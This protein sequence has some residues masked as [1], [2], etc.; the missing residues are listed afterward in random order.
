MSQP[1]A[2]S[3]SPRTGR[4]V[5]RTFG[6]LELR[7]C[8]TE[9]G[10]TSLAVGGKPLALLAYVACSATRSV[11]RDRIAEV[12]W[13]NSG[14]ESALQSIRQARTSLK[15]LAGQELVYLQG[16]TLYLADSLDTDFTA[17]HDLLAAGKLPDAV[18]LYR[19]PF[20]DL[21]AT[22]GADEFERWA[23]ALRVTYR[24]QCADALALLAGQAL[25]DARATDAIALGV[26]LGDI[27]PYDERRWRIRLEALLLKQDAF[28]IKATVADC[29]GWLT[30]EDRDPS[31][32]LKGV[33]ERAEAHAT[34]SL[35]PTLDSA[36]AGRGLHPDLV[37]REAEFSSVMESWRLA[38]EGR[39][40]SLVLVGRAG[41]G[42]SRLLHDVYERLR[43]SKSRVVL[44]RALPADS[45]VPFSLVSRVAAEL[46]NLR[47]AGAVSERSAGILVGLNP[48]LA[49]VFAARPIQ[50]GVGNP[51][52]SYI[53]ALHELLRVLA[54]EKR[55]AVLVDDLHWADTESAQVVASLCER[56]QQS[57]ILFVLATRSRTVSAGTLPTSATIVPIVTLTPEDTSNLLA[58][59]ASVSNH[60]E[61]TWI[62]RLHQAAG[63]SP[64]LI[65]ES[66]RLAMD[67]GA[68]SIT[69]GAWCVEDEKLL[70]SVFAARTVLS[71]RLSR[72]DDGSRD[73]ALLVAVAG[74]PLSA[75]ALTS[76]TGRPL[77][78]LE[79]ILKTLEARDIAS[80][81]TGGWTI[82]HDAIAEV[83]LADTDDAA[84]RRSRL[85]AAKSLQAS[86]DATGARQALVLFVALGDWKAC[87]TII[88]R[89][90]R[91]AQNDRRLPY[92]RARELLAI[93]EP[94]VRTAVRDHLPISLRMPTR[95]LAYV[96]SAVAFS[97]VTAGAFFLWA[98]TTDPS[99]AALVFRGVDD[100]ARSI[101]FS[102]R[103]W[104]PS[105]PIDPSTG[106][107]IRWP[108]G[109]ALGGARNPHD[110]TVA[111]ERFYSDSGGVEVALWHLNGKE[112]RLT[113]SH[114]DDVP[115]S[116][117]PDYSELLIE[118]S[119][120]GSLGH[121]AVWAI[122]VKT[123]TSRRISSGGSGNESDVS[124]M[125]SPDGSRIAFVRNYYALQPSDLCIVDSDG[126]NEVCRKTIDRS[127]VGV[128]G[129]LSSDRLIVYSDSS[130]VWRSEIVSL[131]DGTTFSPFRVKERCSPSSNRRWIVC[132]STGDIRVFSSSD[133]AAARRVLLHPEM[134]SR[135]ASWFASSHDDQS[136]ASLTLSATLPVAAVGVGTRLTADIVTAH[137]L[138]MN[139]VQLRW[140][141]DDSSVATVSA[142]GVLYAKRKG[143]VRITASAGGWRTAHIELKTDGVEP[144]VVMRENWDDTWTLRWRP[145]GDPRPTIVEADKRRAF[146]NRGDGDHFS[147]AYT[148]AQ[149]PARR[150]VWLEMDLKT[151]IT[152]TQ[153][154]NVEVSLTETDMTILSKWDHVDGSVPGLGMGLCGFA[155]PSGEGYSA[156]HATSPGGD[157]S[158]ALGYSSDSLARGAW[159][160]LLLQVFSD[161]RCGY[162][163]NG[164]PVY[165]STL[166][167]SLPDSARVFVDGNSVGTM[168][169][170]GAVAGGTG[171][172][173]GIDWRRLDAVK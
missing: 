22:A 77:S 102:Q 30:A 123:G 37:G 124:P 170:I 128:T 29:R 171:V 173:P 172:R 49:A 114:G 127:I 125:W 70:T 43:A 1:Q 148:L 167:R 46:A 129:W 19:G 69:E 27:D 153:W 67:A 34:S 138:R 11:P 166:A 21:F 58:S 160:R 109:A 89:L 68:L 65:L 4:F 159:Y 110:G 156:T 76:G 94:S 73:V 13:G 146:W 59:I 122:N 57:R 83:L 137:G 141:V 41:L 61:Y 8:S 107:S 91:N 36:A 81:V 17:F 45:N 47:G 87:A 103:S 111:I 62:Q 133:L 118:S 84:L 169:L 14:V 80:F 121:R 16:S 93:F 113:F 63:G 163:I 5:L 78:N 75:E 74:R 143:H 39:A 38:G 55:V 20:C 117:A 66:L 88:E 90:V 23:A 165:I 154:Q 31:R 145:Y 86:T 135:A 60:F 147:G 52:L 15:R 116:W 54:D 44:V 3:T 96:A 119:R 32:T 9:T 120:A 136:I 164:R 144:S 79:P 82:A 131:A 48:A 26:H 126:R 112:Q 108:Q 95:R 28:G 10:D 130:G 161:G 7:R 18:A 105:T 53:E 72:L 100:E 24:S 158:R 139:D 150:G 149:M 40:A 33:L 142:D 104:D 162:A 2:V 25:N 56:S 115:A 106:T 151:E 132:S 42:K 157:V 35:E 134:L 99:E 50:S 101:T 97:A 64:L 85:I 12:L 98:S 140:S 152:A 92:L 168:I 6:Q 51:T 71:D 155:Y